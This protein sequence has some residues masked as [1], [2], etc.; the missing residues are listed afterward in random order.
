MKKI[1]QKER[2]EEL[3]IMIRRLTQVVVF[4]EAWGIQGLSLFH[5]A[6]NE[7]AEDS[8]LVVERIAEVKKD[9]EEL[10]V[11]RDSIYY[12]SLQDSEFKT[13]LLK[14]PLNTSFTLKDKEGKDSQITIKQIWN[15][16]E[17][18]AKKISKLEE[19]IVSLKATVYKKQPTT[20]KEEKK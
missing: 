20:Q 10:T 13:S 2:I 5:E 19:D 7:V 1:N 14:A 17:S 8:L 15:P 6:V 16:K 9:E 11:A 4:N 12:K 18:E 3:E